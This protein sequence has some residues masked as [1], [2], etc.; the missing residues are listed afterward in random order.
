MWM[1]LG[2]VFMFGYLILEPWLPESNYENFYFLGSY[3]LFYAAWVIF[4]GW[5]QVPFVRD[6]YGDNY[7][8]RLWGK[9][10]LLGLVCWIFIALVSIG[11]LHVIGIW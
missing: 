4:D 9:P 2:L 10:I 8:H 6:R 7:L 5:A 1:V 11:M 3:T